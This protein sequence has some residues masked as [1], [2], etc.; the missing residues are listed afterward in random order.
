MRLRRAAR[1]DGPPGRRRYRHAVSPRALR[2]TP[3]TRTPS[4]PCTA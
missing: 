2:L 1:D 3:P 4:A